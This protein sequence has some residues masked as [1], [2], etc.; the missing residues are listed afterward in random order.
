VSAAKELLKKIGIG[1]GQFYK[2]I[3]AY[4]SAWQ[5]GHPLIILSIPT[6]ETQS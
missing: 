5:S 3:S 6:H 1:S 2:A 4:K